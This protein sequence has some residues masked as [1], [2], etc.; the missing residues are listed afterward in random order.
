MED[1]ERLEE[2]E[3]VIELDLADIVTTSQVWR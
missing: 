2:V 1:M 3:K